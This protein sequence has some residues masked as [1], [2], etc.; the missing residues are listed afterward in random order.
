VEGKTDYAACLKN[1]VGFARG[2]LFCAF[3]YVNIGHLKV[4]QNPQFSACQLA[5]LFL[6]YIVKIFNGGCFYC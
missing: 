3:A 4:Q 5:K 2:V 6:P 1:A